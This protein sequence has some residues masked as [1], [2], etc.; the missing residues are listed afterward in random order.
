MLSFAE[1]SQFVDLRAAFARACREAKRQHDVALVE[2]F[3]QENA[4][5]PWAVFRRVLGDPPPACA[6][7][8]MG[9]WEAYGGSLFAADPAA[10]DGQ[11]GSKAHRV[12]NLINSDPATSYFRNLDDVPC[13]RRVW[14]ASEPVTSRSV[15]AECLN[16]ALTGEEVIAAVDRMP[17]RKSPGPDPIPAEAWRCAREPP[18]E[19]KKRP[20]PLL[21]S[22]LH[23][24]FDQMFGGVGSSPKQLVESTWSPILKK[25]DPLLCEN[26]RGIAV[27]SVLGK[28]YMAILARR[29][30]KW[31]S[32]EEEVRHPAQAGFMRGLGTQHHHFIMRH[33]TT[34]YSVRRPAGPGRRATYK[35]LYV[36]QIDFSK[37]F[38]KVPRGVLWERLRERGVHGVMLKALKRSYER[39]LL[40]PRVNGVLGQAFRCDQ[41]VK[42]G[43]PLSPDLFGLFIETLADFIDAMDRH[44]LPVT[45]PATGETLEPCVDDVPDLDGMRVAS[46]LFA[47]DVNLLGLSAERMNYL[48][49]LLAVFCEAFGMKVNVSKC[50]LLVFHPVPS[51]R[52]KFAAK[53]I[54]LGT[55]VLKPVERARYLG[56]FYGPPSGCG[57]RARKS[58]F[59]GSCDELLA[60]GR[61]ATHALQAKLAAHGLLVPASVMLMYNACV[62]SVFSFGAQVWSTPYLTASFERAMLHGMVQEQRAFMQRVVGAQRPANRL[63]YMELSQLPMQHHW[64]GLVLRFWNDLV[65]RAGSLCH[66]A[67]RAD[68]DMAL[69]SEVGWVH[70]VLLFLK[71]LGFSGLPNPSQSATDRAGLVAEYSSMQL[72]VDELLTT[73]AERLLDAWFEPGLDGVEPRSYEGPAGF[74]VCSYSQWMGCP[75]P[76][77]SGCGRLESLPHTR[78]AISK[79]EVTELTRFRLGAWDLAVHRSCAGQRRRCERVC[80][81]CAQAG[82]GSHI[83][84]EQH[85]VIECP[86]YNSLRAQFADRLPFD[87]GMR[88]V[89]ACMDQKAV[90]S[91]VYT[92]HQAFE[93]AHDR[94]VEDVV[95]AGSLNGVTCGRKDDPA[96]LILCDGACSR[97]FHS[98]CV[99]NPP[100]RSDGSN[101]VWFCPNCTQARMHSLVY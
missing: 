27:G 70:E 30:S 99:A 86:T 55:T 78:L 31:A 64:A 94:C 12:L 80:I 98:Y 81:I 41:G 82:R 51:A 52:K 36:C 77:P 4:K 59:T 9:M 14:E 1:R 23:A 92:L 7:T 91:F 21:A 53:D 15:G 58:L 44:Q 33:L 11:D 39:V 73:M 8:D 50:E 2:S 100:S 76:A 6:Q 10:P 85:L 13:D 42:Q 57:A 45:C 74:S 79:R 22:H 43:D 34:Y 87:R 63:L 75:P 46:L 67:F 95:C 20:P 83:E 24:A 69:T 66:A 40:R 89:M 88:E 16:N 72:P 60:A 3:V 71:E 26:Y 101:L 49:A 37:A 96:N 28:L 90:A 19:G 25:G 62:Q 18:G 48:L 29:F 93:R 84:D 35:P 32:E 38:D 5:D 65:K 56:L 17:F 54:M 61:R 68:I 97:G 47:D